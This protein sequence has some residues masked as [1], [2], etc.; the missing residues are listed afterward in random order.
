MTIFQPPEVL[1]TGCEPNEI[2]KNI[3]WHIN[4]YEVNYI[5][6]WKLS[7]NLFDKKLIASAIPNFK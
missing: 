4:D 3:A 1:Q 2:E 5:S 6:I 7:I